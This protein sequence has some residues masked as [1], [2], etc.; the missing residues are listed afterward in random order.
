MRG[1]DG[2]L[3]SGEV[4]PTLT[5]DW[6]SG[7][8]LRLQGRAIVEDLLQPFTLSSTASVPADDYTFYDVEASFGTPRQGLLSATI[9][10]SAGTFFDGTLLSLGARP[11]WA[12]SQTVLITA[13]YELNRVRFPDRA[14][15]FTSHIGRAKVD[16][17]INNR[18]TA[19]TFVQYSSAADRAVANV[20]IRYNPSEGHDLYVVYNHGLITDRLGL[21]PVPPRTE[22]RTVLIKYSRT[23]PL[24]L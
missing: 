6:K 8:T 17:A 2:S 12:L 11:R 23:F 3:E 20:R 22:S 24:G 10:A 1:E 9:T 15:S 19:G 7:R 14:Q 5:L 4:G 21:E 16:L 18:L 13:A